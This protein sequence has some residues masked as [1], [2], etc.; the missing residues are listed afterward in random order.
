MRLSTLL[1]TALGACWPGPALAQSCY[2][3]VTTYQSYA[4]SY[5]YQTYQA[6]VKVVKEY[7]EVVK[8]VEKPVYLA[9]PIY[10]PVYGS[11]YIPPANMP[12]K[13]GDQGPRESA[14]NGNG[15]AKLDQI[16]NAVQGL[17]SRVDGI[18]A[19]V[20]ALKGGRAA[21]YEA[22][23]HQP[24]PEPPAEAPKAPPPAKLKAPAKEP[25]DDPDGQVRLLPM[26][27][28][29]RLAVA[30]YASACARCHEAATARKEGNG[31]VLLEGGKKAQLSARQRRAM[32][33]KVA[34][35]QASEMPPPGNAHGIRPPTRWQAALVRRDNG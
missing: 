12:V 4:P 32:A 31:F 33:E 26:R 34:A 18:E 1:L 24:R 28:V 16:L 17:A 8:Q 25:P 3:G 21:P 11:M 29:Q 2:P 27:E 22:P 35:G 13:N 15:E 19:D 6:P 30:Y 10:Q 7:V 20:R 14:P 5:S 23:R 9:Y